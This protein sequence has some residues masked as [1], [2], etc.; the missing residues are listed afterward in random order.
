MCGRILYGLSTAGIAVDLEIAEDSVA[1]CHK[2]AYAKLCIGV[3]RELLL[4]YLG[5]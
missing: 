2:R 4:W 5:L 1:T 3:E